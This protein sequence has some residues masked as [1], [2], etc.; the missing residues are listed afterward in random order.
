MGYKTRSNYALSVNITDE[1][2]N[3]IFKNKEENKIIKCKNCNG[4]G[5]Q[6]TYRGPDF[7]YKY[8]KCRSFNLDFLQDEE[9]KK[10]VEINK[11]KHDEL[12]KELSNEMLKKRI[13]DGL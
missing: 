1:R 11:I 4:I 2:F 10:Q 5:F 13:K 7:G 3:E 6:E 8:E 9:I 12:C